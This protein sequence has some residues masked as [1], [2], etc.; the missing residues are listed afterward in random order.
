MSKVT[1]KE[2]EDVMRKIHY[3]DIDGKLNYDYILN[4][5]ALGLRG[6]AEDMENHNLKIADERWIDYDYV[7]GILYHSGF[8][9]N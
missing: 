7:T 8:Y 9:E 1:R 6:V 2:F 5:I 4:I 3:A